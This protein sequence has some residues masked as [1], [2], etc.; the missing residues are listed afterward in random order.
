MSRNKVLLFEDQSGTIV[1]AGSGLSA[2]VGGSQVLTGGQGALVIESS[3]IAGIFTG[4]SV[5][6]TSV[7]LQVN[8]TGGAVDQTV[9]VDGQQIEIQYG[10]NQGSLFAIAVSTQVDYNLDNYVI[11]SGTITFTSTTVNGSTANTF[12]G[13]GPGRGFDRNAGRDRGLAGWVLA[14]PCR[15]DLSHDDFGNPRRLDAGAVKRGLD[16]CFAELMGRQCCEGAVECAD[17]R[18]R[19]TDNDNIVFHGDFLPG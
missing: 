17:R 9:T 18:A 19:R 14:L 1:I 3:G 7:A 5:S 10:S 8:T 2:N 6:D 11:V 16:R 15:E 13:N 12:A 4:Q